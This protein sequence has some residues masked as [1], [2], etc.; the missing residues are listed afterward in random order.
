MPK[1]N[2]DDI[3]LLIGQ[4]NPHLTF[5]EDT[6]RGKPGEPYACL[7][8]L[9]WVMNGPIGQSKPTTFISHAKPELNIECQLETLWKLEDD[10]VYQRPEGFECLE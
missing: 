5:P 4:D 9:G 7:T 2:V 1:L 8:A 3:H 10:R 6:R